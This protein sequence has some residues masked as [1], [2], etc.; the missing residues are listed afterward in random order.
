MEKTIKLQRSVGQSESWLPS[1]HWRTSSS[2]LIPKFFRTTWYGLY[3]S[4]KWHNK[5][6][7]LRPLQ[8]LHRLIQEPTEVARIHRVQSSLHW[9]TS[10]ATRIAENSDHRAH[11]SARPIPRLER[12][13]FLDDYG[14]GRHGEH[15][16]QK[17]LHC[18]TEMTPCSRRENERKLQRRR[19]GKEN[20]DLRR[21]K[22]RT[23]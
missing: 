19:K 10:P 18:Q 6:F 12:A 4:L 16:R 23:F 11:C 1:K 5:S 13:V 3:I 14:I 9:R 20:A 15:Y 21:R 8:C 2:V 17:G 7:P 22:W